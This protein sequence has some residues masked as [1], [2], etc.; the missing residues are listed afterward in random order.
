M[1]KTFDTQYGSL[2]IK[3]MSIEDIPFQADYLF[4]SSDEFLTGIGFDL[5]KR[6]P[7]EEY[8]KGMSHRI[9]TLKVPVSVVA[10][11]AGTP[12]AMVVLAPNDDGSAHAHFH[13][14][15]HNLRGKGLGRSILIEGLLILMKLQGREQ[16]LIEPHINNLAMN[17]LMLKCGFEFVEECVFENPVTLSFPARRYIIKRNLL[18]K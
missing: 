2:L 16:A 5:N 10:S 9:S 1:N 6:P 8:I 11:L 17:K 3:P 7:R 15:D 14:W 18:V 12:M 4:N 13:I